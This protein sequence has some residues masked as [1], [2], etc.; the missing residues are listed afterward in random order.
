MLSLRLRQINR[1]SYQI[2]LDNFSN[3]INSENKYNETS[4]QI[5]AVPII[6]Y[7]KI[8]YK[9]LSPDLSD[10]E[11]KYLHDNGFKVLTMSNIK[12]NRILIRYIW[13]DVLGITA[14]APAS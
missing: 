13:G 7:H 1:Q 6:V 8:D 12:Y 5:S 14:E 4:A 9:P 2:S 10:A 3:L 11:M